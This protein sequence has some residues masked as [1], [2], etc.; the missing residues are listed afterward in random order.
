MQKLQVNADNGSYDIVVGQNILADWQPEGQYAVVTDQNVYDLYG[1][2]FPES[3]CT[4]ILEPG[5]KTKRFT[6]LEE[7]L[8]RLAQN[9]IDRQAS[10][11]ALGGGVVGDITGL[12]AAL[13][14]R[15]VRYIQIPTTLLAQVDSSVGG[16]VAVN[17]PSGK[18]LAGVFLQPDLVVA[19]TSVLDSL[20][21]R[22]FS[23]G[24]AE[25]I[26]Y[27]YIADR[28]LY[29]MLSSGVYAVDELVAR[30]CAIKARYVAEDPYDTG[31]RMQL[32]YGHTL[33]HAIESAA[34]YGEYLHGEAVGAGMV[35]AARIGEELGISPAGLAND[36]AE[37]VASAGLPTEVPDEVLER[38]LSF[39]N[40]DKKIS[41]GRIHFVLIDE[42]GHAVLHDLNPEEIACL[43]KPA[44]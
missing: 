20:P 15:G 29:D 26:K 8:D 30:C 3:V 5:E 39:L 41:G 22:E 11:V 37:L 40:S 24:M 31:V 32:N 27:G 2:S 6:V 35:Y 25:V 19:D 33:G 9:N 12:A 7:I 21:P 13:Y 28:S 36:T 34:G 16:K 38:A 42:I 10:I 43:L 18:N 4:V 44:N 1:D 23:A 14:K 17:L